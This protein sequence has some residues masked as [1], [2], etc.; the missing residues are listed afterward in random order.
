MKLPVAG[1]VLAWLLLAAPSSATVH[2]YVFGV[3]PGTTYDI[4]QGTDTVAEGVV[5][6]PADELVFTAPAASPI[7]IFPTGEAGDG[8]A[9]S[10]ISTL[11]IIATTESTETLRWTAVGDDGL[12]GQATTYDV[13]YSTSPITAANW[14][15]ATQVA[16]EP[17]PKA[18]GETETFTVTG[19]HGAILYYLA[20]KVADEAQNWSGLSNVVAETTPP[21]PDNTPPS[22]VTNLSVSSTTVSTARLT[23]T[24]VGDDGNAGTANRYDL[25]YALAPIDAANWASATQVSGETAPKAPGQSESFT[26]TGLA[27]G[28]RYYFALKVGDEVPNWS[29]LSNVASGTTLTPDSTPPDA[30][31]TLEITSSTHQS[32]SFRWTAVGDDGVTGQAASYDFRY[33]LAP[34][35]ASNWTAAS[36]ATGEPT[37]KT[38]GQ[39]EI[40]T[41]S[42]LAPNTTYYFALKVSDEV[43]NAS[44]ISNGV[45]AGTAEAPDTTPPARITNLAITTTAPNSITLGWTAPGDDGA[46]GQASSYDIR[47]SRSSINAGNWASATQAGGEPTPGP[48]GTSESFTVAGLSPN[49]RYYFA[50]RAS[51]EVPNQ[52]ELSNVVNQKTARLQDTTPPHHINDL[53]VLTIANREIVLGW[54]APA[55]DDGDS[56]AVYEGRM[57]LGSLD[58]TTWE[59]ATPIPNLPTPAMPGVRESLPVTGLSPA[60]GY[61]FAVRARDF[62]GNLASIGTIAVV[63]TTSAPDT[64]P[65][66]AVDDLA[67]V[68][69]TQTAITLRWHAPAD[70]IPEDCVEMPTV[71]RYEIRFALVSLEGDGWNAGHPVSAPDPSAPGTLEQAVVSDLAADTHYFFAMR[72]RDARGLWSATSNIAELSTQPQD[73]LPD[74]TPPGAI[75]DLAVVNVEPTAAVIGW[76]APGGDGYDGMADHYEVRMSNEPIQQD[77]WGD[78]V[79]VLPSKPCGEVGTEE[80]MRVEDLT[81]D[82]PYHFALRAVDAAGNAGPIS[83]SLPL[84]TPELPDT[85]APAAV[86]DLIGATIDTATVI[87]RWTAPPDDHGCT[88]YEVRLAATAIDGTNWDTAT[89]VDGLPTPSV[90]GAA[91]SVLVGGLA[92]GT[93]FAFALRTRDGAGN[94]SAVSNV[95]WAST[96]TIPE[97]PADPGDRTAPAQV[98][99]L[100]AAVLSS[101]SVRLTWTA[102]GDDG[103]LGRASAYEIRRS[104]TAIDAETWETAVPVDVAFLPGDPGIAEI[105]TV[106]GLASDTDHHFAVRVLD[107]AGNVSKPSA[108]VLA[109]TPKEE[110]TSPPSILSRPVASPVDDHIEVAWGSSIDPDVVAYV[111]Y[112]REVETNI[113]NEIS[114]TDLFYVD[115]DVEPNRAYAYAIS[116]RDGAGNLSTPTTEVTA[117]VSLD[118][119]LPVISQ[120]VVRP[121]ALDSSSTGNKRRV[122]LRW[123]AESVDR[124]SGFAVDRSDDDGATWT[125]RTTTLLEGVGPFEFEET[126][127][128]GE[129]LYRIVAVSP[130]GFERTFDPIPVQWYDATTAPSATLIG[131]V[132]PNPS[133]GRFELP[134][135]LA[136][137]GSLRVTVHDLTGRMLRVLHEG[138]ESAGPHGYAWE[139]A[140]PASGIYLVRVEAEGR[141]ETR[142]VTIRK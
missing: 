45:S 111:V 131:D 71:D 59:S 91:D 137:T 24:S 95:A 4:Q 35:D 86:A 64:L 78:A 8:T 82:S 117:T 68:N 27:G 139:G 26:V 87:L 19:L 85:Q 126:I 61:A 43:P 56:V 34:I 92:P 69:P 142:K 11:A 112:R 94:I 51:D 41:L 50:V 99:D 79:P 7:Y 105:L 97:P 28:T 106:S 113:R 129:Y 118:A 103:A 54:T 109:H 132:F 81:P 134:L 29:G 133:G 52:S 13:R 47:Y 15:S 36:Q 5:P 12:I 31:T 121:A 72:A 16:G 2:H 55:D 93:R 128:P 40:F 60:S 46:V 123:S 63:T 120:M 73:H 44:G 102:V 32:A 141:V 38:A 140:A 22:N 119:F 10:S 48:A 110:D 70:R 80:T 25:R 66:D 58:E 101:T 136:R 89:P 42:G 67:A 115:R 21:D 77:T 98:N 88:A 20:V 104:S 74:Q 75:R 62:E 96:D 9:P 6:G 127:P 122:V 130:K 135:S 37:P 18:A 100:A 114:V 125:P 3:A 33:A 65:P 57:R 1:S 83:G 30:V 76:I 84:H 53:T 116:A 49:T 138:D 14:A 17:A 23:W 124:L 108:D 90:P 39:T 107:E